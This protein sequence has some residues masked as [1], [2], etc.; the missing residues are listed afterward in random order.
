MSRQED[1]DPGNPVL[2]AAD[3]F[4]AQQTTCRCP[5]N[6]CGAEANVF[7][8]VI[9]RI[10]ADAED[11]ERAAKS[12]LGERVTYRRTGGGTSAYSGV[13]IQYDCGGCSASVLHVMSDGGAIHHVPAACLVTQEV[14]S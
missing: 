8:G 2:I 5:P 14:T 11:R 12:R 1:S 6:G 4:N 3:L 7:P 10:A 9:C 13:V